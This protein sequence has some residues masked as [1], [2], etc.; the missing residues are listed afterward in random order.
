M[1]ASLQKIQELKAKIGE[2]LGT[3]EREFFRSPGIPL[4]IPR[5]AIVEIAGDQK[6]E[7]LI[8][9]LR[10]NPALQAIW[11]EREQTV[12]PPALQQREVALERVTFS[13]LD[14]LYLAVRRVIQS[15]VFEVVIAPSV[16]AELRVLKA[17][18][19]LAE[20]ANATLFLTA[21]NLQ[22][23]WPISMQLEINKSQETGGMEVQIVKHKQAGIS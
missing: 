2:F 1:S 16:F 11:I 20:K 23:A 12:F 4:G 15:Q 17:L 3:N 6:T 21:K 13:A 9:L 10:E 8:Q 5:G 18:Q 22:P 7:W 14:E 19:L